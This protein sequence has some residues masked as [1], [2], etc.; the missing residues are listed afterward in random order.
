[1]TVASPWVKQLSPISPSKTSLPPVSLRVSINRDEAISVGKCSGEV[2]PRLGG[3]DKP[4][5]YNHISY[6][7]AAQEG[8]GRSVH[9][10]PDIC[11]VARVKIRDCD[12]VPVRS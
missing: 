3:G 5:P 4:R 1:M 9:D 7:L 6:G 10:I 11:R 8:I 12:D 2:Y